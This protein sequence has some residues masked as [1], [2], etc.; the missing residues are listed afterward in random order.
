MIMRIFDKLRACLQKHPFCIIIV[1]GIWI[2]W[3][4]AFWYAGQGAAIA[5]WLSIFFTVF[6]ILYMLI[7]GHE[8]RN[9]IEKGQYAFEKMAERWERKLDWS[10]GEKRIT[11]ALDSEQLKAAPKLQLHTA[12]CK[13]ATLLTFYAVVKARQSGQPIQ[14]Y[15]IAE[16]LFADKYSPSSSGAMATQNFILGI[17]FGLS[18]FLSSDSL[19][20][21]KDRIK[22]NELPEEFIEYMSEVIQQRIVGCDEPYKSLL[23]GFKAKIDEHFPNE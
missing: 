3:M 20:F 4:A 23:Q 12:T 16:M 22:I 7:Q 21:E 13:W 6:V 15:K 18:G 8:M 19:I 5:A 17:I 1:F 9:L 10:L 11:K 14:A 2:L